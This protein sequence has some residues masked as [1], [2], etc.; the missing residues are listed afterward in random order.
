MRQPGPGII[1]K[2][3]SFKRWEFILLSLIWNI[4]SKQRE[5]KQW[6]SGKGNICCENCKIATAYLQWCQLCSEPYQRSKMECLAKVVHAKKLVII[7][8]KRSI[9]DVWQDEKMKKCSIK[10]TEVLFIKIFTY[11]FLCNVEDYE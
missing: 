3:R 1:K 4:D 7:F 10:I 6:S 9:L 11:I 5:I 8:A 2:K